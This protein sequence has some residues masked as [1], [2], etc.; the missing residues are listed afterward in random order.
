[1]KAP[2]SLDVAFGIFLLLMSSISFILSQFSISSICCWEVFFCVVSGIVS[3]VFLVHWCTAI[4]PSENA[5]AWPYC[6]VNRN[7]KF[8]SLASLWHHYKNFG[9]E[10]KGLTKLIFSQ[11]SVFYEKKYASSAERLTNLLLHRLKYLNLYL[12]HSA[13]NFRF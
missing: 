4:R 12:S 11:K 9:P 5:A 10:F 3:E 7:S 6:G 13:W 1:M 2:T 8:L